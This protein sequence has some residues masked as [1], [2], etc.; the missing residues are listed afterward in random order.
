MKFV[1]ENNL[2]CVLQELKNK[3][4]K[5]IANYAVVLILCDVK[6]NLLRFKMK[7]PQVYFLVLREK[8]WGLHKWKM[9]LKYS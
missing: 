9:I 5:S 3:T 6:C 7:H 4:C 1:N 2:S 8:Y